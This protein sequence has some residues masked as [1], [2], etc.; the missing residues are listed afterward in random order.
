MNS[1]IHISWDGPFMTDEQIG[2]RQYLGRAVLDGELII[3]RCGISLLMISR[4]DFP[5]SFNAHF[6]CACGAQSDDRIISISH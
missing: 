1:N 3:C 6:A 4:G 5:A 2:I